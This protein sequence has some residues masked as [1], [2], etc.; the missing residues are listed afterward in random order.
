MKLLRR[1]WFIGAAMVVVL[2]AAAGAGAVSVMAFGPD[3]WNVL[4]DPTATPTGTPTY[5]STP[6]PT[7]TPTPTATPT[8][9]PTP[10]PTA[11]P[12]PP[13]QPPEIPSAS[14]PGERWVSIDLSN[15]TATAMLGDTPIYTALVTTG[16]DGWDT[17]VGTWYINTRVESETMSSASIGAEDYYV[18]EDVAHTQYFTTV[19][20]ALHENYWRDDWVFGTT[21]SSHGCVGMRTADAAFFWDFVGIGSRVVIHGDGSAVPS[22]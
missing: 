18:L 10:P 15:Q 17:P 11:T 5:T 22:I 19:G 12:I 9:S 2:V 1:P 14:T 13:P 4:A 7:Q 8:A 3:S 21:R 16:K 6:T 20:H